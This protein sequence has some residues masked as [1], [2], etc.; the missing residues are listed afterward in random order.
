[1]EVAVARD[2]REEDGAVEECA[3]GPIPIAAL[4]VR[5]GTGG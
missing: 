5:R 3:H 1:M 2:A 4:E